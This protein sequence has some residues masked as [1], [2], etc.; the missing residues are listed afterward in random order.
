MKMFFEDLSTSLICILTLVD[1]EVD[2]PSLGFS[3]TTDHQSPRALHPTPGTPLV[4][5]FL[6]PVPRYKRPHSFSELAIDPAPNRK[7]VG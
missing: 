7:K 5:L 6:P 1:K 3:N 2:R 4:H